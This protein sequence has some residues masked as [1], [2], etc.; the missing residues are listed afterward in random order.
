MADGRLGDAAE[1]WVGLLLDRLG[2]A[3]PARQLD[4]RGELVGCRAQRRELGHRKARA[5]QRR[6]AGER[7]GDG[8]GI[9]RLRAR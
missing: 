7:H 6:G 2:H 3:R 1:T 8:V 5:G 9:V 4:E